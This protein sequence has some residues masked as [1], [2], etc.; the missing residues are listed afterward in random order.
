[1]N[2]FELTLVVSICAGP[3]TGGI[4]GRTFGVLGIFLG[5]LVGFVVG[6]VCY[7]VVFQL[8]KS[9]AAVCHS[10]DDPP[11]NWAVFIPWWIANVASVMMMI[12]VPFGAIAVTFRAQPTRPAS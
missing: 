8:S 1:M 9:L 2:V 3:I 5:I 11:K 6:T 4:A 7:V 10:M 12:L